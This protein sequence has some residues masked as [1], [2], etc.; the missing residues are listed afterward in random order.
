MSI[1]TSIRGK[2]S[3]EKNAKSH[4]RNLIRKANRHAEAESRLATYRGLSLKEKIR[5]LPPDGAK[6][7][8]ERLMNQLARS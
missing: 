1:R 7:Q 6:R 8:R 2:R 5:H 3:P 4:A